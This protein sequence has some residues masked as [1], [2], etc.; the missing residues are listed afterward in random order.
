MKR[1]AVHTVRWGNVDKLVIT[2]MW[3][4]ITAQEYGGIT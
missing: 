3:E 4:G 2:G 1:L